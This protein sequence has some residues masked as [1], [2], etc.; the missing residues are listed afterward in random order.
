MLRFHNCLPQNSISKF[1]KA[2]IKET[3]KNRSIFFAFWNCRIFLHIRK[4]IQYSFIIDTF[5]FLTTAFLKINIHCFKKKISNVDFVFGPH[6]LLWSKNVTTKNIHLS[7]VSFVPTYCWC[8]CLFYLKKCGS[9]IS[10][11]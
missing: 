10:M 2:E 4:K 8:R 11:M 7:L 5:A 6:W 3:G 1:L 9:L